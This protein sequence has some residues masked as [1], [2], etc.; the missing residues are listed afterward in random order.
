MSPFRVLCS[1]LKLYCKSFVITEGTSKDLHNDWVVQRE[2]KEHWKKYNSRVKFDA[3]V[4]DFP[5]IKHEIF[6]ACCKDI[7]FVFSVLY[8]W[9]GPTQTWW[10]SCEDLFGNV[11]GI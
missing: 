11:K 3:L 10:T 5:S 2:S 9:L 8:V 7:L 4:A 1:K 6:Y